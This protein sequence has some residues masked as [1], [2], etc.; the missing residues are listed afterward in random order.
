M[1]VESI[2]RESKQKLLTDAKQRD[3]AAQQEKLAEYKRSMDKEVAEFS[4]YFLQ[5]AVKASKCTRFED[6]RVRLIAQQREVNLVITDG[7]IDCV[8]TARAVTVSSSPASRTIFVL[9]PSK[10]DAIA[11]D[12]DEHRFVARADAMRKLFPWATVLPAFAIERLP[13]FI[14]GSATDFTL[15]AYLS[16]G[17]PQ[18]GTE[19]VRGAQ[20]STRNAPNGTYTETPRSATAEKVELAIRS[21]LTDIHARHIR[22]SIG[23]YD[24][25]CFTDQMLQQMLATKEHRTIAQTERDTPAFREVAAEVR[26]LGLEQQR[27]VLRFARSFRSHRTWSELGGDP[28][29]DGQTAAGVR[30]ELLISQA[31]ADV[32]QEGIR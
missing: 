5:A 15:D 23:P 17:E 7:Q 20:G 26:G 14:A 31:V 24:G 8:N 4:R 21:L 1:P 16:T 18:R 27:I 29:P 22:P 10:K 25:E 12:S 9:V 19:S 2:F 30:A 11:R 32:L 3:N 13:D 6:V 28:T